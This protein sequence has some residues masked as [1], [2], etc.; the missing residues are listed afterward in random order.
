MDPA[1]DN[2]LS[3]FFAFWMALG[4]FLAVGLLVVIVMWWQNRKPEDLETVAAKSRYEIRKKVEA[5]EAAVF[6]PGKLDEAIT[7]TAGSLVTLKPA[8]VEK[9][10]QIVPGS[11]RAKKMA[12][13]PPIDTTAVDK[14]ADAAPDTPPDPAAMALGEGLFQLCAACHGMDA[15][16]TPA[17]PPLAASEW[18]T[19]PVSNVIR[20]QLRG[21]TGPISV[22][23]TVYDIPNGMAPL[24]AMPDDQ[25]AAV[26]TYVRNSFGNKASGVT[27]EQVQALRS[28]VGKPQLTAAELVKP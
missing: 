28:E 1:R 20:I 25:I 2:P 9:P 4:V 19:G 24:A 6:K 13:A 7:K 26:L 3:R 15:K 18:V 8:A 21:L 11:E 22:A 23:G 10:E 14:V 12:D 27:A 17:G 5:A 16:G